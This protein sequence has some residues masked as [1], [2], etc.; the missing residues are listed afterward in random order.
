MTIFTLFALPRS[1]IIV[2]SIG[3]HS[4]ITGLENTDTRHLAF[5]TTW[6]PK[7]TSYGCSPNN[8]PLLLL[9]WGLIFF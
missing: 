5:Q 2:F 4:A 8:L 1:F 9:L 7:T 3:F 6:P